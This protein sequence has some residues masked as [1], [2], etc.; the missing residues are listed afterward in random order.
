MNKPLSNIKTGELFVLKF[1][2]NDLAEAE[3]IIRADNISIIKV[4][5]LEANT[6][7]VNDKDK[8][9]LIIKQMRRGQFEVTYVKSC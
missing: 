5:Y 3:K 1:E 2:Y 9:L 7:L 6:T 8:F 4:K